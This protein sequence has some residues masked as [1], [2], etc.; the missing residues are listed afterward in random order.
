MGASKANFIIPFLVF[1]FAAFS[2]FIIHRATWFVS[3]AHFSILASSFVHNDLFLS[4]MNLPNGDY[5]D[6]MGKQYLFFGPMPSILLMPFAAIWGRDFPQMSLSFT[7]LVVVYLATFFLCIRLKLDKITSF[8]L[9]NFFVFGTVF[10]FVGLVNISAYVVQAVGVSFIILS[11][12]EYFGRRRWVLIGL[13]VA[14]AGST[15]ITL[16]G[17]AVFYLFEIFR[18]YFLKRALRNIQFTRDNLKVLFLFLVPILFS[19]LML[20]IYNNRRFH[21]PFDTGYT[22][23]VSILDKNYYNYKLG[24]FNFNHIPANLYEL[25]FKSP[26]PIKRDGVEFVLKFPY[27]KADG[28]G[29]GIIFTS[30][31]FIYLILAKREEYTASAVVAIIF[32]LIPSLVYWGIGSS[33]YG[34]RYSL[35]FLPF[36]FLILTSVFKRGLN[37]FAKILIVYGIVFNCFY[38]ISIWNSYPLLSFWEYLPK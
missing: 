38:M 32:L 36:L 27:L 31:L 13:M 25:L 18:L 23:N 5:V 8:W 10:Y 2:G 14:A 21:S 19:V 35:D 1:I 24:F 33:Q 6:Y 22:K 4:P 28:F 15:R 29:M 9:S 37:N 12:L 11:L 3:D 26:E 16:Y 34:Y 7:S 17:V 20:G 30:P